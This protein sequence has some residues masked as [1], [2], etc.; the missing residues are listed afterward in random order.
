MRK[1]WQV[2]TSQVTFKGFLLIL[3]LIVL[4]F[5]FFYYV[6]PCNTAAS[7]HFYSEKMGYLEKLHKYKCH[8]KWTMGKVSHFLKLLSRDTFIL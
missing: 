6:F 3:S 8:L 7:N 4:F 2:Q 5:F 1:Y